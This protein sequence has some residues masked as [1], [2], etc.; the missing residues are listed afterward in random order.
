M[1]SLP[2]AETAQIEFDRIQGVQRWTGNSEPVWQH[3]QMTIRL[4]DL[5]DMFTTLT[6]K[7]LLIL[8]ENMSL[9]RKW[10]KSGV[11]QVDA[12]EGA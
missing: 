1:P 7:S 5:Q 10:K 8:C 9:G 11:K 2:S 4:D 12:A 3:W 6:E